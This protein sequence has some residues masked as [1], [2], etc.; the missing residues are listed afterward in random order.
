M[1]VEVRALVLVNVHFQVAVVVF[2]RR[3]HDDRV[4]LADRVV[5]FLVLAVRECVRVLIRVW[6]H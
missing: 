1:H 3:G 5:V 2:R 6:V 4:R